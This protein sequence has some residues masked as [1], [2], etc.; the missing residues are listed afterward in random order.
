MSVLRSSQGPEGSEEYRPFSPS[1]LVFPRAAKD[2]PDFKLV[3]PCPQLAMNWLPPTG[4]GG[5]QG[6]VTVGT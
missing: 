5:E 3:Q 2:I 6:P 4:D 1:P